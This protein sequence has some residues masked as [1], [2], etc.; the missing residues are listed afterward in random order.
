MPAR[1]KSNVTQPAAS[2]CG[3]A[4][5]KGY[6]SEVRREAGAKGLDFTKRYLEVPHRE[7]ES[8]N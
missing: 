4:R 8:A 7:T 6:C 5:E 1:H 2:Q 3:P